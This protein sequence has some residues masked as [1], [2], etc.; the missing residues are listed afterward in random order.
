MPAAARDVIDRMTVLPDKARL[1][2]DEAWFRESWADLA[3][4]AGDDAERLVHRHA[5]LLFKPEAF[6]SRVASRT[7]AHLADDGFTPIAAHPVQFDRHMTRALWLYRFNVAT[8][9]RVELHDL[10]MRSGTS[11]LTILRDERASADNG[12]TD[13]LP[14]TVRL[15]ALK[16]PSRPERRHPDHLRSRLGVDDR[17]LNRFHTADEPADLVRELAVF[18]PRQERLRLLA[19]VLEGG[20]ARAV[21]D[22]VAEL[23]RPWPGRDF[24]LDTALAGIVATAR[25]QLDSANGADRDRWHQILARADRARAGSTRQDR[26]ALWELLLETPDAIDRWDL[27]ALGSASIDYDEL[28]DGRQTLGDATPESWLR[29]TR[30]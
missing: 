7:L 25:A 6:V 14:A 15:T 2:L 17:I 23:E 8:V 13:P 11:L 27:A 19:G 5:L 3:T 9:A 4:L 16:G 26:R 30:V 24:R 12:T 22:A 28:A 18:L 10:I 29:T 1:Y 20:P 21:H